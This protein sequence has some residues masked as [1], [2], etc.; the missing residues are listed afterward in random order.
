LPRGIVKRH[1]EL[2]CLA[3]ARAPNPTCAEHSPGSRG[4]DKPTAAT[5]AGRS[6]AHGHDG[7]SPYAARSHQRLATGTPG[8]SKPM[9]PSAPRRSIQSSS[10][11]GG[12]VG[13]A[14]SKRIGSVPSASASMAARSSARS[15]SASL[16]VGPAVLSQAG[17]HAVRA[18]PRTDALSALYVFSC[19]VLTSLCLS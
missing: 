3:T 15:A 16:G 13:S 14:G 12:V 4:I 2:V 10:N 1:A 9:R 19:S 5:L 17:G 11:V 8:R 6:A 18:C 7:S